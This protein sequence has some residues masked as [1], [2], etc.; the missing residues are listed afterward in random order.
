MTQIKG[1]TSVPFHSNV[2]FQMPSKWVSYLGEKGHCIRVRKPK[3]I[4]NKF[5]NYL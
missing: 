5:E 3:I 2:L 4:I 1:I